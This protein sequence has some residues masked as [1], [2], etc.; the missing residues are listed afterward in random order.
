MFDGISYVYNRGIGMSWFMRGFAG[1]II[2]FLFAFDRQFDDNII[3]YFNQ[4]KTK[5]NER[6]QMM[7]KQTKQIETMEIK[8][9]KEG[10]GDFVSQTKAIQDWLVEQGFIIVGMTIDKNENWRY[11][12]LRQG[13]LYKAFLN[14]LAE[15]DGKYFDRLEIY[16]GEAFEYGD[17]YMDLEI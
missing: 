1:K 8:E 9:F 4:L 6:K 10:E 17:D 14:S 11:K 3:S 15:Q 16:C 5:T 2:D 12:L 13:M 7:A